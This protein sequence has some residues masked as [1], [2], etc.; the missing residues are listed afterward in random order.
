MALGMK[1][2]KVSLC[3]IESYWML[4]IRGGFVILGTLFFL[5]IKDI[6]IICEDIK[7]NFIRA[8]MYVINIQ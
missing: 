1:D 5:S 8:L 7:L 3:S 4:T 6:S 2:Y